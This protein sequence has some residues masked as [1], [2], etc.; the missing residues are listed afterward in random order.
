VAR[1]WVRAT[2]DRLTVVKPSRQTLKLAAFQGGAELKLLKACVLTALALPA[3]GQYAGPAILS[4]GEAPAAMATQQI[5]FRPYLEVT[6][7]YDTGLAGVSVVNAQGDLGS[8]SA[9]GIEV[10]GG[11][12]GFHSWKHTRFG[13]DYRGSL[14]NYNRATY[15]DQTDQFLALSLVHQFSRRA[16][17]SLKET[18]GM[19]SRN[20]G[21]IGLPQTA[22]YDPNSNIIPTTDFYDNRTIY[23]STRGD[24]TFQKTARLS[25]NIGGEGFQ[26]RRRSSALYGL[27]GATARADV[28]YR[29]TRRSTF[30]GQYSYSHYDYTGILGGTDVHSGNITYA[31]A[32]S[33]WWEV[34]GFAGFSRVENLFVRVGPVSS[35]VQALLGSALGREIAYNVVYIPNIRIRISRTFQAGVAY[36]SGGREVM[37]GNGLFL[38]ST[39]T[40]SSGGYTF[41][42]LRRWSF[43]VNASYTRAQSLGNVVGIYSTTSGG[44]TVSRHLGRIVH[45]LA[46]VN[47]RNYSSPNF[48]KYNRPIYE[49]RLGLGFTPGDVPLRIW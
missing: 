11:I 2:L 18:A 27:T 15:F 24:L 32:P 19:F 23:F 35:D 31:T 8:I 3:F 10:T 28:Q 38:T 42:G 14:R 9:E 41:T 1:L 45:A 12:S 48:D 21:L 6:G 26:V 44:F 47:A 40:R 37:P 36:A 30:G 34:S 25:F 16:V 22:G 43:G 4:R 33:R 17:L 20:F 13:L 39:S 7:V 5:S 49:V 29:I 46:V